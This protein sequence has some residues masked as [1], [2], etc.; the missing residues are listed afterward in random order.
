MLQSHPR[1]SLIPALAALLFVAPALDAQQPVPPPPGTAQTWTVPATPAPVPIAPQEYAQRRAALAAQMQD[2]VFLLLGSPE[3]EHDYLPFA[4]DSDFRY[5]TGVTEPG[6]ALVISKRNGVVR[7]QLFVL[8]RNPARETWEGER[9][10]A[11]R[12]QALTGIPARTAEG[13]DPLV[14]SLLAATPRLY[15][16]TQVPAG[17]AAGYLTYAQQYQARLRQRNPGVEVENVFGALRRLRAVKSPAELAMLR[18]A[19]YITVLA[20]HEVAR[21]VEPGLNEFEIQALLEGTFRR[22][23][24][25]RPAFSSIVGSGPNSTTLHYRAADRF[26]EAQDVVVVDIG[27]SYQG[28]AAD[29]TRTYPVD[30][31]FS[32]DQRAVYEIVLAAQ[33]AAEAQARPGASFPQLTTIA[34][35][36]VS[37]G[38]ARLGL[39][40]AADASYDCHAPS[41]QVTTCPQFR[42]FYMHGLGHGIG[43]DV[44]DPDMGYAAFGGNFQV[45]SAFTLEPGIYVRG[46][47]LDYL[48]DTPRNREMI[49]RIRPA[50]DRYRHIGVRLEDDYFITDT[51]VERIT[52]GAP[53]EVAEVEALMAQPSFWNQQ[54]RPGVV[55]WYRGVLPR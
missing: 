8:P 21:A 27:A 44:H 52:E 40:E 9:L 47:V 54:R 51:G 39:I 6:A 49:A 48:P 35:E 46:D 38:L 28:Y 55:E 14:D 34:A 2:G 23:G 3:T 25:D 53:R 31:R 33:K 36:V 11:E 22:H 5:L 41:G 1:A 4:Q 30:G 16:T 45:G 24:A 29:V 26:M 12:A 13:L 42:L 15:T 50:V 19:I 43:L 32:P 18:R 20:H 17:D 7:E 37:S 10:G